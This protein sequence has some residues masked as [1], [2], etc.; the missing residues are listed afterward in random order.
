[1]GKHGPPKGVR[2]T[3]NLSIDY[4]PGF[5]QGIFNIVAYNFVPAKSE[6][7]IVGVRDSLNFMQYPLH[8]NLAEAVCTGSRTILHA[9]ILANLIMFKV[10]EAW[11]LPN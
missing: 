7:L 2:G 11:Q 10:V 5:N 3:A 8:F 1:M 6:Q 9:I 4:D